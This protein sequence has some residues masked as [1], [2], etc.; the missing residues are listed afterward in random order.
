MSHHPELSPS[1]GGAVLAVNVQPGAGRAE[2]VGRYGD[3]LKLRMAALPTANRADDSAWSRESRPAASRT[4]ANTVRRESGG[5]GR[6]QHQD[7]C[8]SADRRRTRR[9]CP[10]RPT[11]VPQQNPWSRHWT[12]GGGGHRLNL[13]ARL[14]G[15]GNA[16]CRHD[17]A[18]DRQQPGARLL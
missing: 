15:G 14:Q 16:R 4:D 7:R 12:A 2:V 18:P 17:A 8:R 5:L 1:E 9:P 13:L 6:G 11:P 10:V 3:A